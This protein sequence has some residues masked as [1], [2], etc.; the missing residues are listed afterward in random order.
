MNRYDA[1]LLL[2]IEHTWKSWNDVVH[3]YSCVFISFTFQF[4]PFL[5]S[6][7]FSLISAI[8][9]RLIWRENS[10]KISSI[11]K[12]L[13]FHTKRW[14]QFLRKVAWYHFLYSE[15]MNFYKSLES[16]RND[17][18]KS[19]YIAVVRT[20]IWFSRIFR[21][22][23]KKFVTDKTSY[24]STNSFW[25]ILGKTSIHQR[26]QTLTSINSA[27]CWVRSIV[28]KTLA[29][30]EKLNFFLNFHFHFLNNLI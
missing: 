6:S 7:N 9:R 4:L 17:I 1:N 24:L 15:E 30:P 20:L 11:N 12:L 26:F 23:F 5:R 13:S 28:N 22:K 29:P 2:I 8:W 3:F 25:N 16:W 27:E 10:T 18:Y 14:T 21:S 19:A